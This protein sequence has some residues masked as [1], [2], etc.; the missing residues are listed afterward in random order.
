[1]TY[2]QVQDL[3]FQEAMQCFVFTRSNLTGSGEQAVFKEGFILP[4]AVLQGPS[5]ITGLGSQL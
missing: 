1:M 2:K 5:L 4:G 3:R